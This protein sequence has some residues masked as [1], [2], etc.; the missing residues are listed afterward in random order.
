MQQSAHYYIFC[1]ID[2]NPEKVFQLVSAD[3]FHFKSEKLVLSTLYF[4]CY[5]FGY[6]CLK[7]SASIESFI[8]ILL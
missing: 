7:D 4:L 6:C 1:R 2:C 8:S 3:I 5:H